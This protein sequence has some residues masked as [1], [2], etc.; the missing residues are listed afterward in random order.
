MIR[1]DVVEAIKRLKREP[2]NE[3]Q[4]HGSGDLLQ[5]LIK[6]DLIDAFRLWTFPILLGT[7]KRLFAGGTVPKRLT[8]VDTRTSSTGVIL[9]VHESAGRLEYGSFM[10]DNPTQAELER[11]QKIE[12]GG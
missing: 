10:L 5:T 7:G 12:V 2:G 4:V 9:Q 11:R 8:L 3:L 6:H 1:G